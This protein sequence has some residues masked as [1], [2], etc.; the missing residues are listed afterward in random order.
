M[1]NKFGFTLVEMIAVVVIITLLTLAVV[2]SILRQINDK[3]DEVSSLSED[4]I[5]SATDLYMMDNGNKYLMISGEEYYISLETLVTNKYLDNPLKDVISGNDIPLNKCVYVHINGFRDPEYTL[6]DICLADSTV[7]TIAGNFTNECV[8]NGKCSTDQIRNGVFVDVAVDGTYGV[9]GASTYKFNVIKDDG[10][11]LTLMLNDA[12]SLSAFSSDYN[13]SGPVSIF[14]NLVT[15]TSSWT[16]V[17]VIENYEYIDS[18]GYTYGY[19]GVNITAGDATITNKAG[20]TTVINNV[21]A[22]VATAEEIVNIIKDVNWNKTTV[23][24][25]SSDTPD[26]LKYSTSTSNGYSTISSKAD[27]QDKVWYLSKNGEMLTTT[28]TEATISSLKP[29]IEIKKVN[30][31]N[32]VASKYIAG[33]ASNDC[34]T[35]S[36]CSLDNIKA[37]IT[38]DVA[39]SGMLGTDSEDL[40]TFNVIA[41]DGI[42]VTLMLND[43]LD[44]ANSTT[45]TISFDLSTTSGPQAIFN[46]LNVTTST[47]T[48][49]PSIVSYQFADSEVADTYGYE[50]INIV[51]G[52]TTITK[53]DGSPVTINGNTR[54]RL[55]TSL[56]IATLINDSSW[57]NET[58]TSYN[59]E[60]PAW[61]INNL[62][63]SESYLTLNTKPS[64]DTLT[65]IMKDDGSLDTLSTSTESTLRPVIVLSKTSIS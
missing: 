19:S 53:K 41:D 57:D 42:N 45:D 13:T 54:A 10:E 21:K 52:L 63:A 11:T 26:W 36:T 23:T 16:N 9:S 22:R 55:I 15:I 28:A 3:N 51:E 56:E 34:V 50:S 6:S 31:Q 30:V 43:K 60:T 12:S 40:K 2:P 14:N 44:L 7:A 62:A 37:G 65:W 33:N 64:S 39:V 58:V 49:V 24:S 5:F 25:Y 59:S 20:G 17:P 38:V 8:I 18:T 48:N 35:D 29:V 47:W 61:L 27:E 46:S 1:K 32:Y 4:I